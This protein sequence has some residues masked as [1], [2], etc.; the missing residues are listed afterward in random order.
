MRPVRLAAIDIGSNSVHMVIADVSADGRMRV[1]DRVKEMVRLGRGVFA[2]GELRAEAMELAVRAVTTFAQLARARHVSKIRAVATAAVREARNGPLFVRRLR[3]EAGIPI[4]VIS[5]ADEARLIFRAAQHALGLEGGPYLLIDIGGGSVELTLAR[6]G[7]ALWMQSVPLGVARLTEQFLRKDPPSPSQVRQL[8]R[9]IQKVAGP[10]LARARKAHAVRAVGTS[11]T[12]NTLVAMALAARGED[13]GRLHGASARAEEIHAIRLQ[14]TETPPA[15][16]TQI[17]GLE[18]KRNDLMPAAAVLVDRLL[19]AAGVHEL[20]ACGWALREGVLLELAAASSAHGPASRA[21]RRQAVQALAALHNGSDDAHGPHVAGLATR[22]FDVF[23]R[24]LGVRRESRELLEY[25]ALLHDIGHAID[26]GGHHQHTAYLVRNSELLG[27]EPQE[28]EIMAL[29]AQGHRKQ[30]PKASAPALRSLPEP[31]RR[32][33]RALAAILR[34]CDALD[35]TH[36]GVLRDVKVRRSADRVVLTADC[37]GEN[38]ELE[39]WA[40]GR[41]VDLLSR[42]LGRPVVVRTTN[43]GGARWREPRARARAGR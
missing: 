8:E 39:L 11:G 32:E 29:V 23:W 14:V 9:H 43:R 28:I 13:L 10:A 18:S 37:G 27:F 17:A 2:T 36:F 26:H 25:A 21:G 30:V 35:R 19:A 34:L 6:H 31:R 5:G 16:R 3:R 41:R 42:L 33:V 4:H 15:I 22:L 24:D 12:I 1:V 40:A 20:R 7:R 38:A